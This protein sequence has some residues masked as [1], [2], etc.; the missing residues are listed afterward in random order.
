M[1]E[2]ACAVEPTTRSANAACGA[3]PPGGLVARYPEGLRCNPTTRLAAST[4]SIPCPAGSAA[5]PHC[6]ASGGLVLALDNGLH[7]FDPATGRLE[8]PDPCWSRTA[9]ATATTT[10]AATAAAGSG[11]APW[12]STSSGASGSFYRI[13][14]DRSVL[15]LFDGITVPNSTAF[16]PDDRTLYFADTPRHLIW[17]F[18][19]DIARRA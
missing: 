1:T 6:G 14:A 4:A 18:D 13:G 3:R 15:R 12:T 5:V 16:S 8:F 9:A 19:F 2:I 17:A 10:A 7:G 11:S